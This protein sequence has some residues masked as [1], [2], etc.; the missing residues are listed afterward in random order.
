MTNDE[1][2]DRAELIFSS[3]IENLKL[4]FMIGLP[5]ETDDDLVAIRDL[6][7]QLREIML[8]HA[9]GKGRIGRIIGSVNPLVPKPSTAYQWLPMADSSLIDQKVQRLREL[10]TDIDNVFF[11]IKS[12]RHSFYQA[13]LS[14]G[15]RRVAPAIE[16][17]EANGGDWRRA[18]R[19]PAS[20]PT[21]LF[22]ATAPTM[23]AAVEHH[24]RRNEGTVL[25]QRVRQEPPRTGTLPPKRAAE[26]AKL[27]AIE[28]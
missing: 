5:T 6:T 8:K 1:I 23:S 16:A 10:T 3:G 2:L 17:A 27:I 28:R 21:S 15:D 26:N 22:S 25:P 7:L 24:R 9:M 11:N 18:V 20:T 12:E 14:L 13:L 4:Y 19:M